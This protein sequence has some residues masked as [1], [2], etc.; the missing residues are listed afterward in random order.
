MLS[1]SPNQGSGNAT[2]K[3]VPADW[4]FSG[5]A[6]GTYKATVTVSDDRHETR[7][8]ELS[9]SVVERKYP[10][11]TYANGPHGCSDVSD[12]PPSNAAVCAVPDETP[13][14]N[15]VPPPV[16]GSYVDPNFGSRVRV[17]SESPAVHGYST[18]SPVSATN[19]Y[20]LLSQRGESA[21]VELST[22]KLVK[23]VP[24]GFEGTLWDGRDDNLL[25]YFSQ[26][27]VMRYNL[28]NGRSDKIVDYAKGARFEKIS[29]G[30]TGEITKD[31][32]L[33]FFA[34]KENQVCAL[35]LN[36]VKTYCGAIP[37]NVGVDYTTMSKGVDRVSGF[38]YVVL[39]P[40]GGP[41]V[42]Y[43]VDQTA[44]RLNLAGRGPENV[45]MSG[46]NRDGICDPGEQ[47]IKGSHSD[48]MAD[49]AGNQ[50]LVLGLEEQ[51]P[52]GFSMYTIQLAKGAQMGIP[53]ELGGGL[54]R[55]FP[56]FRC[57][58][59]DA[60]TD[61]HMGCARAAP[62]CV[63]S[64]A[65]QPFNHPR[66][67]KDKSPLKRTPYVGEIMV[68]RDNGAE[69]Q[70]L[71]EHRTQPFSNE[72]ASGYWSTPR[73]ALSPDGT[74]V[75]ATSNFGVPNQQRVIVIGAP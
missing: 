72:E 28:A 60:W 27:A 41:F 68:M 54:K 20:V 8:F 43:T 16:G 13:P 66:D 57:G 26:A 63:F 58:R 59:S 14:G 49:S 5:R 7:S 37:Q 47:C 6:P 45:M 71:A 42:L 12:L 51:A 38:R 31:N 53:V 70:R 18:P 55:V 69:V 73:G 75:V 46:G 52:C 3:V 33:S 19:K 36:T 39:V 40:T 67:P 64:I 22:G 23:K 2:V 25:Y 21:V 61:D 11:L 4:W 10:K 74:Y 65:A 1:L 50:F 48:T 34:P 9:L 15:F 62:A 44:G 35:D 32:W 17:I 56:L 29:S 24:I 30:G